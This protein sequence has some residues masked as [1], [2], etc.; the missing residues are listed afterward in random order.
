MS[1]PHSQPS[2]SHVCPAGAADSFQT[3]TSRWQPAQESATPCRAW[4]L[5]QR[6]PGPTTK[7]M[8]GVWSSPR[9]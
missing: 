5:W 6:R 1:P 7:P 3:T 8:A 2:A 9:A 4:H